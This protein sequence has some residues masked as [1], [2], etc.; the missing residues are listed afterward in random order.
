MSASVVSQAA[1]K[2]SCVQVV[3]EHDAPVKGFAE[4]MKALA[5][6][7][8]GA[9][10]GDGWSCSGSEMSTHLAGFEVVIVARRLAKEK[11]SA[12]LP[13]LAFAFRQS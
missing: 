8:A 10:I 9:S 7:D 5:E 2:S 4:E 13:H 6:R 3:S 12:S 1:S 11:H